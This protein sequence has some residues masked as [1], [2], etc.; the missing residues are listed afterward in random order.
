MS[1]HDFHI[2]KKTQFF[3]MIYHL[4]I[5]ILT[6]NTSQHCRYWTQGTGEDGDEGGSLGAGTEGD[7]H[8]KEEGEGAQVSG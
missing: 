3:S 7:P 4:M 8:R 6:K 1:S 5:L 2:K